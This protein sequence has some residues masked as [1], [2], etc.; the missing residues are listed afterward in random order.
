M[1]IHHLEDDAVRLHFVPFVLKDLT[2][3]W[4]YSLVVDSITSWENFIK[5]FVKNSIPFIRQLLLG[6]ISCSLRKKLV[7]YFGGTLNVSKTS[8]PNVLIMTQR[9]GDSAKFFMTVQTIR[10]KPSQKPC[11]KVDSC[12]RMK[13]KGGIYLRIQPIKLSNEN[14]FPKSLGT[15]IV[16]LQKDISIKQ[17]HP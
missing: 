4:I 13:T 12:R 8:L 16:S 5:A 2:K 11:T 15:Q 14:Q 1:S 3:K 9:S 10:I 7:N 17:N 6:R